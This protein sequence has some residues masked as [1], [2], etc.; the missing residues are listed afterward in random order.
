MI[1]AIS[2]SGRGSGKTT[3]AEKV[4]DEVWSIAG[5]LRKD[6]KVR[7]PEYDWYNKSQKYKDSTIVSETGKTVRQMLFEEGQKHSS[8]DPAYWV[9]MLIGSLKERMRIADGPKNVAIDDVRKVEELD[10]IK[11]A[12]PNVL[13]VHVTSPGAIAEPEFDNDALNDRADYAVYW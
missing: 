1:V 5:L 2:G 11:D 6:L 9:R 12:F 13:H 3:L 4:S 8:A 10:A 7:Y